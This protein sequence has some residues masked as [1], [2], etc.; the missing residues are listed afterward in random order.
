M[1][2]VQ[3]YIGLGSNLGDRRAFLCQ[4]L[5]DLMH[6]D[7][8]SITCLSSIYESKPVGPVVQ[9][10]FLNMVAGIQVQL[11]A[12]DLLKHMQAI[13]TR[14]GRVRTVHWGPR[15]LDLDLLT[16]DDI[17]YA[18]PEL[19][20]PHPRVTERAFV[21]VPLVEVAPDI[22][23]NGSLASAHLASLTIADVTTAVWRWGDA[24][25]LVAGRYV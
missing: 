16:Y 10:D 11:P 15:Q 24:P 4:G 6:T 12:Q 9:A 17:C 14:L 21:L 3:A 22:L 5:T 8:I 23:I 20:L 13:E 25:K 19:T 1:S 2:G 7:G 18:T